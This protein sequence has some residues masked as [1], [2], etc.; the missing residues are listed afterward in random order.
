M[1]KQHVGVPRGTEENSVG[2]GTS[3]GGGSRKSSDTHLEVQPEHASKSGA[4]CVPGVEKSLKLPPLPAFDGDNREDVDALGRWLAKLEKHAEFRWSERTK[5]LQFELHLTGRAERV[6]EL[7]S[8]SVKSSFE[9][10]SQALC[11][12]LYPVESEALVSAQ[13]MR[14]KQLSNET[15]DEFAQDLEKLFKRSHGRRRGMDESSKELLKRDIFVQGL[16]L[17]WQKKVLPSAS[18]FS[19]ALHQARAAEQ[20]ERQ[21]S[22]MHPP[23]R[24]TLK[25]RVAPDHKTLS[26]PPTEPPRE[27]KPTGRSKRDPK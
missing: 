15:V 20:Q 21:L 9:E 14:C 6:Y 19:D 16:L 4:S 8:S 12:R 25:S 13:L 2:L 10:A 22:R 24:P 11:E 5:L 23:P 3:L 17:K 27:N 1:C 18:T 26:A 7:L